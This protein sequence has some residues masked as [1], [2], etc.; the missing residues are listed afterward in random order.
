MIAGEGQT[1]YVSGDTDIMADMGWMGELH[2]PDIGILSAGGHY[3]M[4]MEARGLGRAEVFQ[5]QDRDPLPLPH[6][7]D[8]G[9]GATVLVVASPAC[10]DR[11]AGAGADRLLASRGGSAPPLPGEERAFSSASASPPAMPS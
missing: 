9:T 1:I 8:P 5:L 4:D 6:L 10:G 11:T 3:T 7:P 2:Q